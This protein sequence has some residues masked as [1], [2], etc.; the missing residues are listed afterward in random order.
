MDSIELH[1]EAQAK[2]FRED[3]ASKVE[4]I[5]VRVDQK[6]ND[7]KDDRVYPIIVTTLLDNDEYGSVFCSGSS[8]DDLWLT[9]L[10]NVDSDD[11]E[12]LDIGLDN[13]HELLKIKPY[14][15]DHQL[16][17]KLIELYC[18]VYNLE[19]DFLYNA[20]ELKERMVLL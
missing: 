11:P 4:D 2:K 18:F 10:D 5:L 6:L 12:N 13:Y 7:Y 16:Q 14:K 9:F 19:W 17:G 15:Y 3:V 8:T 20:W 1:Q